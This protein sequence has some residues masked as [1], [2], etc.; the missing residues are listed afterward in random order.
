MIV[1]Y[2]D[3][4]PCATLGDKYLIPADSTLLR[5]V[6]DAENCGYCCNRSRRFKYSLISKPKT[7]VIARYG[8][9]GRL[10]SDGSW[11]EDPWF[12]LV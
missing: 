6:I 5:D 8:V 7:K 12:N 11:D 3:Y 4:C 9:Y 10:F 1:C 2:Y